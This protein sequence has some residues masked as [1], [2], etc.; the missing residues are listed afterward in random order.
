MFKSG[1]RTRY[2]PG[3]DWNKA[4]K[5]GVEQD[6]EEFFMATFQERSLTNYY[7]EDSVA[8]WQ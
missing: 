6:G 7:V 3:A 8:T 4:W 5:S 1:V 2:K